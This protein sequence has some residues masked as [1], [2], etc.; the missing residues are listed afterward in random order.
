MI[1]ELSPSSFRNKP[2]NPLPFGHLQIQ[3]PTNKGN[4]E[5]HDRRS[6]RLGDKGSQKAIY[7]P[8]Y[9][10]NWLYHFR[11]IGAGFGAIRNAY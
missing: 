3:K 1:Q 2:N 11:R 6:G 10:E 8:R 4:N 9:S 5:D 7:D